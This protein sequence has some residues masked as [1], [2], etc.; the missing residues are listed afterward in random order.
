[1]GKKILKLV[2]VL[3][4]LVVVAAGIGWA[5]I[6]TLAE[7]GIE[8]GAT[9]ALGVE[10]TVA[11]VDLSLLRGTLAIDQLKMANPSGFDSPHLINTTRV[12]TELKTDTLF[13][14]TVELSKF[15]IDGLDVNIEGNLSGSNIARIIENLKKFSSDK[16]KAETEGGKK[17]KVDRILITNVV[18]HFSLGK[19][20]KATVKVP[21]I[22]LRDVTSD[23]AEGVVISELSARIFIAV[24]QAVLENS[25]SDLPGGLKTLLNVDMSGVAKSM[26]IGETV[27]IEIKPE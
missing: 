14:D 11:Q 4:I 25:Q 18:A 5:M 16:D 6:D 22:E 20:A 24:L 9:Y 3:I 26:G 7:A 17:I 1:M 8:K 12:A 13:S 21:P 15:E 2:I 23:N 10:T 27:K 19:L